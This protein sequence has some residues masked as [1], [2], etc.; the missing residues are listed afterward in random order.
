MRYLDKIMG[1]GLE[2]QEY[3]YVDGYNIINSWDIFKMEKTSKLEEV[4]KHLIEILVE[5]GT[6]SGINI[7]VVFDAHLLKG[8]SGT[9]EEI[10]GLRVVY[11]QEFETADHYIERSITRIA[12]RKKVRVATSDKLEQEI[13]LSRGATRISAREL[14]DEIFAT[15]KIISKNR[16]INNEKN[17]YHFGKL[18]DKNLKKLE[19]IVL[20]KEDT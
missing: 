12:R 19:K 9:E 7:V 13:I 16:H 1:K 5:Y 3:L 15:K 4:R 6:Y 18:D 8:N 2:R 11:T 14:K 10:N 20:D 17:D